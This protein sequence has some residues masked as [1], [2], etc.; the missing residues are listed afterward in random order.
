MHKA[1]A[2]EAEQVVQLAEMS[3]LLEKAQAEE[4]V[5]MANKSLAP[6]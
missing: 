3:A 4:V 2:E 1:E 5:Q 6:P